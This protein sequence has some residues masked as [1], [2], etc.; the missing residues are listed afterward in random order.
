[1]TRTFCIRQRKIG[2]EHPPFIIAEMSGNHNQS[3]ERALERLRLQPG[4]SVRVRVRRGND[5]DR[6]LLIVAERKPTEVYAVTPRR[7][8][9]FFGLSPEELEEV[10]RAFRESQREMAKRDLPLMRD[11]SLTRV[12]PFRSHSSRA[13]PGRLVTDSSSSQGGG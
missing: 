12:L 4:D 6:D 8:P 5:R 7:E 9:G 2:P 13:T 10:Q 3:L 11:R 1:M